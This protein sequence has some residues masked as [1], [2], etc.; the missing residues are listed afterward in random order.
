MTFPEKS[1]LLVE[2]DSDVTTNF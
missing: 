2:T 1:S